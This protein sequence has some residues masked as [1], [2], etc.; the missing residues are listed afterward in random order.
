MELRLLM[1]V[2]VHPHEVGERILFSIFSNRYLDWL[3]LQAWWAESRGSHSSTSD[4]YH[5]WYVIPKS[6]SKCGRVSSC[7]NWGWPLSIGVDV[8]SL[9]FT[10]RV[11][12]QVIRI[13]RMQISGIISHFSQ[14]RPVN[15][16]ASGHRMDILNI[17]SRVQVSC[18][19]WR[20]SRLSK[21]SCS[22]DVVKYFRAWWLS[23]GPF[24]FH[25]SW[26]H[27]LQENHF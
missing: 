17:V 12:V 13:W 24:F 22:L 20:S 16:Q 7:R 19:S 25:L 8:A 9:T 2:P 14:L 18:D 26:F 15:T 6:R 10:L 27:K 21:F 11:L 23:C 5:R 4:A 3:I 1:L